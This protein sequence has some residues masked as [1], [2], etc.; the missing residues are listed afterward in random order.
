MDTKEIAPIIGAHNPERYS[1]LFREE[2]HPRHPAGDSRGGEFA[3]KQQ[4]AWESQGFATREEWMKARMRASLQAMGV[5]S[6]ADV[7]PDETPNHNIDATA[8]GKMPVP[9]QM[10]VDHGAV[11]DWFGEYIRDMASRG[12]SSDQIASGILSDPNNLTV[13]LKGKDVESFDSVLES[14][15]DKLHDK[16]KV[17]Q[18]AYMTIDGDNWEDHQSDYKNKILAVY[19][20]SGL[21]D[22]ID[23]IMQTPAETEQYSRMF[24]EETDR[25]LRN[26]T[27][28]DPDRYGIGSSIMKA[29]V[30]MMAMHAMSK[31]M[32]P[33]NAASKQPQQQGPSNQ[34]F[35]QLHPR[36]Q[37]K[38]KGQFTSKN[39]SEGPKPQVRTRENTSGK[40]ISQSSSRQTATN[41]QERAL[42]DRPDIQK[43]PEVNIPRFQQPSDNMTAQIAEKWGVKPDTPTLPPEMSAAQAPASTVREYDVD[44][45]AEEVMQNLQSTGLDPSIEA[46]KLK[47]NPRRRFLPGGEQNP[48]FQPF[49][50]PKP[51]TLLDTP[52]ADTSGDIF[53]NPAARARREKAEL[54]KLTEFDPSKMTD[55]PEQPEAPSAPIKDVSKFDGDYTA[56]ETAKKDRAKQVESFRD[57][58]N[59]TISNPQKNIEDVAT[60]NEFD[61]E[62]FS[63]YA[64]EMEAL[65]LGEWKR[66]EAVKT[67]IRKTWQ[68]DSADLSTMENRRGQDV[69]N[70]ARADELKGNLSDDQIYEYLGTDEQQW[71]ENA[72]NMLREDPPPR[73]GAHDREWLENHAKN[74]RRMM[75]H[76][77]PLEDAY[78]E[79]E[80]GMPFSRRSLVKQIDR[81][82]ARERNWY[83]RQQ[84]TPSLWTAIDTWL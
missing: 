72:W 15:Y 46:A 41:S 21:R 47:P 57:W 23:A 26:Y 68:V 8:I 53:D 76:M 12:H 49:Q 67:A 61:H 9:K 84:N 63:R 20:E 43:P 29:I 39:Q 38:N 44:A 7:K 60:E 22:S 42:T 82:F 28:V 5:R 32:T 2:E 13:A 6:A 74:Y 45:F 79:P 30:G 31:I 17:P 25:Y 18:S 55:D 52:A 36:G 34:S 33:Q 59:K 3:G 1:Q 24:R 71:A 58:K 4:S 11:E 51:K 77:A 27:L 40:A 69:S 73:P 66:R 78:P 35:E 48:D 16:H 70:L 56:M 50:K 37:S 62:P 19:A 65:E 64:N 10:R 75:E 54:D 14:F 83:R 80:D 81:Y